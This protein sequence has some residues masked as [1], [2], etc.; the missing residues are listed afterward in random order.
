MSPWM[1]FAIAGLIGALGGLLLARL[2]LGHR[3]RTHDAVW[4]GR[5]SQAE[6]K[7]RARSARIQQLETLCAESRQRIELKEAELGRRRAEGEA[8]EAELARLRG[9]LADTQGALSDLRRAFDRTVAQL[10]ETRQHLQN[11]YSAVE[12]LQARAAAGESA[13]GQFRVRMR[14]LDEMNQRLQHLDGVVEQLSAQAALVPL[15]ERRIRELEAEIARARCTHRGTANESSRPRARVR[16]W[17]A[18]TATTSS[19]SAASV[20]RS[21]ACCMPRACIRFSQIAAWTDADIEAFEQRL[22][23]FAGRIRRDAWIDGAA[24]CHRD[25]YG[26]PPVQDTAPAKD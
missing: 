9:T 13:T 14:Q 18:P 8:T 5:L 12:Q 10:A 1:G 21:S 4:Q 24:R 26:V 25:K 20:P 11:S 2:A 23:R 7:I 15:R 3:A 22:P 16:R 19:R 6:E 17:P